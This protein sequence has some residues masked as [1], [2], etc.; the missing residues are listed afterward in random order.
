VP[1]GTLL[2]RIVSPQSFAELDRIVAPFEQTEIMMVRDRISKVHP[3]DY[4]YI[5]GDGASGYEVAG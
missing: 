2:G 5:V 1:K 4:A 3:G